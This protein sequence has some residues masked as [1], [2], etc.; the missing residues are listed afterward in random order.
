MDW[1]AIGALGEVGG[2]VAV[3]VTLLL[4][5]R[6]LRDNERS[7]SA[8]MAMSYMQAYSAWNNNNTNP[9]CAR[10]I[11]LADEPEQLDDDERQVWVEILSA[12]LPLWEAVY[13]QH[14]RDAMP[15]PHWLVIRND[16]VSVCHTKLGRA[17]VE[18]FLKFYDGSFP[19]FAAELRR[20]LSEEP[21]YAMA[22]LRGEPS[23]G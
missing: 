15:E 18:G 14:R 6:Q 7:T 2:A 11:R 19:E 8:A 16:I 20:C 22:E 4:L 12:A 5:L 3:V 23:A 13:Y 17:S 21:L 1:Q 10:V 9:T